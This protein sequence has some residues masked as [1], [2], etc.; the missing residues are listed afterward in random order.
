MK[1]LFAAPRPPTP[2]SCK[3]VVEGR[4]GP[5]RLLT[6]MVPLASPVAASVVIEI[7]PGASRLGE[8]D[9][10]SALPGWPKATPATTPVSVWLVRVVPG[11]RAGGGGVGKGGA[12]GATGWP[13]GLPA[14][15]AIT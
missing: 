1:L 2:P 8:V 9:G 5:A 4:A 10:A 7:V 15:L 6:T 14:E 3:V 13:R 12:G 11:G